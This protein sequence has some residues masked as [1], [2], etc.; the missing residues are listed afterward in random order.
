MTKFSHRRH[1]IQRSPR[2]IRPV[3]DGASARAVSLD[4][5]LLLSAVASVGLHPKHSALPVEAPAAHSPHHGKAGKSHSQRLS[6]TAQIKAEYSAFLAA[7]NQ[8]LESYVVSLNEA[9]TNN[10]V[11]SATVTTAY[12]V[13]SPIIQVDDAAVFGPAG[14]FAMPV[15]ATA[16]VGTA[17]PLGQFTLTGSSGNTLTINVAASSPIPLTVGTVLTATVPTSAASSAAAIFPSYITSSTIAMANSLVD[18]FNNLNVKLPP[19]NAP[20]HTPQQRGAVQKY[21]YASIAGG[22]SSIPSLQVSLLNIPLPTTPGSDLSI[23]NAT[24]NSVVTGSLQQVLGGVQQIFAR[25]LLIAATP[26]ANR[27]GVSSSSGSSG[28]G[29]TTSSGSSTSGG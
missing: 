14:T 6:P 29:S 12:A 7:F 4:Q 13:G 22:G 1:N 9:S 20:P 25:K 24:V 11:V 5:R 3:I 27:L 19:E 17:P 26:P 10:V 15:V 18:Y 8:Q 28:S 21:V 16:T 2:R 23:Y